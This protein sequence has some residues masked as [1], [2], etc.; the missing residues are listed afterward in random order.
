MASSVERRMDAGETVTAAL[1]LPVSAVL[2]SL[3]LILCQAIQRYGEMVRCAGPGPIIAK[4]TLFHHQANPAGGSRFAVPAAGAPVVQTNRGNLQSLPRPP[5][6]GVPHGMLA[7]PYL[8]G[9]G[10]VA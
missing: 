6:H 9:N 3:S 1:P 7:R 5:L 2:Q 8:G 10:G 4:A